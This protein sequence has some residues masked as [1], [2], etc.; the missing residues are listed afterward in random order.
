MFSGKPGSGLEAFRKILSP[1]FLWEHSLPPEPL[2]HNWKCFERQN[3]T[4][5]PELV[6]GST[7]L[8]PVLPP[9][10]SRKPKP[11]GVTSG[12]ENLSFPFEKYSEGA[13]VRGDLLPDQLSCSLAALL[14]SLMNL[15]SPFLSAF[16]SLSHVPG[17]G[18]GHLIQ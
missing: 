14:T 3:K 9:T 6:K 7:S 10:A 16:H 12:L 5:E 15:H 17:E 11:R 13:D 18:R 1:C 4:K 8:M 2:L